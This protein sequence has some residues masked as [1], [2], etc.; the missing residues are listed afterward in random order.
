MSPSKQVR[1]VAFI[2]RGT[3]IVDVPLAHHVFLAL[4]KL[5]PPWADDPWLTG[6]I[7]EL[8]LAAE[9]HELRNSDVGNRGTPTSETTGSLKMLNTT[10][11]G[12]RLG[13][14]SNW[15]TQQINAGHLESVRVGRWH[16]ITEKEY[17]RFADER[18]RNA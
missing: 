7:S 10:E 13:R 3:V 6:F 17:R 16:L 9:A 18:R 1:G 14:T 8:R 11:V 12:A 5:D 4:K 15:V 2:P